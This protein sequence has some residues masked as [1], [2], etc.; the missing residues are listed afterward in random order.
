MKKVNSHRTKTD[1]IPVWIIDDNRHFCYIL[2][3]S[4]N[5][6]A[7][8]SCTKYFFSVKSAL[9][10]LEQEAEPPTVI[11]LDIKMPIVSGLD[12]I[13]PLKAISPG[14]NIL[15][16]TSFDMDDQ[17]KTA[18]QRGASGYLLKTSTP[19]DIIRSIENIQEGGTPLDPHITKKI[20][21]AY[22]GI[23]KGGNQY[24]L[25]MKE[26]QIIRLYAEGQTI[27]EI[28]NVLNISYH[29]A[30]THRRNIFHKL[31]INSLHKLV[32]KSYQENL[33]D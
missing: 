15:M 8:V 20:M 1:K 31:K 33:I 13:V 22:A 7:T 28:A 23:K 11:L 5:K 19:Y 2:S 6:S 16:V 9:K 26:R 32:V 10:E 25:T 30:N 14:T 12:A 4:L 21:E 3:E 17:I 24:N 27:E 29:T 18:M